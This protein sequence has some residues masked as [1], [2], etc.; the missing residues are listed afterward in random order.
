ML[1]QTRNVSEVRGAVLPPCL[2]TS[3]PG[4]LSFTTDAASYGSVTLSTSFGD[5]SLGTTEGGT[6]APAGGIV[7]MR[8]SGKTRETRHRGVPQRGLAGCAGKPGATLGRESR[9]APHRAALPAPQCQATDRG[10]RPLRW[11]GSS[12]KSHASRRP[13]FPLEAPQCAAPPCLP[14]GPHSARSAT[15]T[16]VAAARPSPPRGPAALPLLRAGEQGRVYSIGADHPA[17]RSGEAGA[18]LLPGE[19]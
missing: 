19:R 13:R 11:R 5:K 1:H 12:E 18:A 6:A 9:T 4:S 8:H 14:A 3:N 16:C 2:S 10:R 7:V 17:H 15:R